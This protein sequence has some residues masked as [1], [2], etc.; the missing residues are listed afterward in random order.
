MTDP[1]DVVEEIEAIDKHLDD[2]SDMSYCEPEAIRD[3]RDIALRVA[4]RVHV[5]TAGNATLY[6]ENAHLKAKVSDMRERL[7]IRAI[8]E[9]VQ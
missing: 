2:M 1:T 9:E 7:R 4:G 8:S 3:Y 6:Q 5:L